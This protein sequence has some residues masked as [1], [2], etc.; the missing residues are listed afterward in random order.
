VTDLEDRPE[1]LM[2]LFTIVRRILRV[3]HLVA[4]A[5]ECVFN[6]VKTRRRGLARA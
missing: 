3:F 1:H 5:E 4:V 6:V 2:P